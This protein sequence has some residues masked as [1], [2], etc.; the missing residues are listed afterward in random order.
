MHPDTIALKERQLASLRDAH[1]DPA[2]HVQAAMDRLQAEIDGAGQ[3]TPVD[4]LAAALGIQAALRDALAEHARVIAARDAT[5]AEH[6][7]TIASLQAQLAA[8]SKP[9]T[10]AKRKA[11]A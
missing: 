10:T 5:I 9:R 8:R 7:A 3:P 6:A 4:E 1:P 11:S 2:P